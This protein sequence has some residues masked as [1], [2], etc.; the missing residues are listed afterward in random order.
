MDTTKNYFAT[1]VFVF[2]GVVL[3]GMTFYMLSGDE[4]ILSNK[5]RV[6]SYFKETQGLMFGSVVSFSGITI[7]NVKSISYSTDKKAL[8]VTYTIKE[9]F[10]PL[11]KQDSYAQLKTQGA[12]G[13]RYIFISPGSQDS[14]SIQA[15]GEVPAKNSADIFNIVEEKIKGIPDLDKIAKKIEIFLDVLNSEDGLNGN[16]KELKSTLV[17]AKKIFKNI[18]NNKDHE[19][20][21]KSLDSILLKI[22]QGEGSL[23]KLINDPALYNKV[24]GFLGGEEN[25]RSYLKELGQKTIRTTENTK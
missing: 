6:H 24:Q 21:L 1:G 2:I 17:E 16:L 20:A 14:P 5:E 7:G 3:F 9:S 18:N 25:S 12:L 11:I 8:K 19:K 22:D 13:D 4:N 10:L 15:G 23:G